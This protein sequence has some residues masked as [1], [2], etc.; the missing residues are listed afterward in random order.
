MRKSIL[1]LAITLGFTLFINISLEAQSNNVL[2]LKSG[3]YQLDKNMDKIQETDLLSAKHNGY[4][5]VYLHFSEIP[6]NGKKQQL[7]ENGVQLIEY[8]PYYTFMSKVKVGTSL[9]SLTN[10][11]VDGIYLISPEFKMSYEVASENYPNHAINGSQV[12][13]SCSKSQRCFGR[14]NGWILPI[15]GSEN[16]KSL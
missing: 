13:I 14:R 7:L 3:D 5:Y 11:D 10:F 9:S 16:Y 6:T 1:I 2:K 4:Y 8:L 12:K 15:S